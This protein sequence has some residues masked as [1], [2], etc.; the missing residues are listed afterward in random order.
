MYIPK[1]NEEII[2]FCIL[3]I[4]ILWILFLIVGYLFSVFIDG[5]L[6]FDFLV[7]PVTWIALAG[8]TFGVSNIGITFLALPKENKT[9]NE[10]KKLFVSQL[11]PAWALQRYS[12][13]CCYYT[14]HAHQYE[15]G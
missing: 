7:S 3:N 12:L 13:D 8:V 14:S 9:P 4:I 6:F 1:H 11:E 5:A 2:A 15:R 10:I